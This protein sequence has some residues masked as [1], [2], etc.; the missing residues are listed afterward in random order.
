ML[1]ATQG[2]IHSHDPGVFQASPGGGNCYSTI[3]VVGQVRNSICSD[4]FVAKFNTA[5]SGAASLVYSTYLGATISMR[6]LASPSTAVERIRSWHDLIVK[7]PYANGIPGYIGGGLCG[8]RFCRILEWRHACALA[9]ISKLNPTASS[10]VFS[11]YLGGSAD[12]GATAIAVDPQGNGYV[13]GVTNSTNFPTSVGVTHLPILRDCAQFGTFSI[14]CRTLLL[15]NS[16]QLDQGCIPHTSEGVAQTL[17][18][19]LPLIR[20]AVRM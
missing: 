5:A 17:D 2:R 4:G 8:A 18:W 14:E 9:F 10:F 7:F 12:N 13:T 20:Q 16:T 6:R 11:T 15:Q 19:A 1:S 3:D